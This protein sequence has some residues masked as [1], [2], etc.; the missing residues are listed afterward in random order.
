MRPNVCYYR[1][2][3]FGVKE[4]LG[5]CLII[6]GIVGVAVDMQD[7]WVDQKVTWSLTGLVAFVLL[8]WASF[9]SK[10]DHRP[11]PCSSELFDP[12]KNKKGGYD[13]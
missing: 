1:A 5:Y 3:S 7:G 6:V 12:M 10:T 8:A 2:M 4:S 9:E 11:A 13:F